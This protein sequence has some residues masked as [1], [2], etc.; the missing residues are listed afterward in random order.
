MFLFYAFVNALFLHGILCLNSFL[1]VFLVD[2][3]E[4]RMWFNSLF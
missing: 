2:C 4:F 1:Q 3:L